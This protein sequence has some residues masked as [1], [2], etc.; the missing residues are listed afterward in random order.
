MKKRIEFIHDIG[1]IFTPKKFEKGIK[2]AFIKAG[3]DVDARTVMGNIVVTSFILGLVLFFSFVF[4][5]IK[6]AGFNYVI[7]I[8]LFIIAS[9]VCILVVCAII[10]IIVYAFIS[11]K[12]YNRTK[13]IEKILPDFLQLTSANMRSGMMIDK[14]LYMAVRPNF[15]V[16]SREIEIVAKKTITGADISDALREFS[17]KYDSETLKRSMNLLIEGMEY[18]GKVADLLNKIAWNL[19]ESQLMR[20]EMAASVVNYV[21]FIS[22]TVL[23]A[24][25]FLFGLSYTLLNIIREIVPNISTNSASSMAM[26]SFSGVSIT[27]EEFNI[28]VVVMLSI[29]SAISS[30]IISTIQKGDIKGGLKNTPIFVAV[31][32]T[33][34]FVAK[35][36]LGFFFNGLF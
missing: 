24:A 33:L 14:A 12:N 19:R 21:I 6:N 27:P 32:I 7:L 8:F 5:L 18:G 22:F 29:T 10:S 16:L 3:M 13:Q 26:F 17:E 36:I 25:P 28:F 34:Y 11:V 23:L 4:S 9:L 30:M 15:G 2:L 20:N 31:T 35:W 1:I